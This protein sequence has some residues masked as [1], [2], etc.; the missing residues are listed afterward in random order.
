MIFNSDFLRFFFQ[1]LGEVGDIE[2]EWM[3]FFTSAVGSKVTGARRGGNPRTW[4]WTL[5]ARG[6]VWMKTESY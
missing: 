1:I 4:W 2:C 6:T 3:M 5:E